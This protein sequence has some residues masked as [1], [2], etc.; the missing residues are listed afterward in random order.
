MHL[1]DILTILVHRPSCIT[2]VDQAYNMRA[3]SGVDMPCQ[4]REGDKVSPH[5]QTPDLQARRMVLATAQ[6][7][8]C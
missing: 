8:M 6:V 2:T 5:L 1:H 3:K 7:Q 4:S